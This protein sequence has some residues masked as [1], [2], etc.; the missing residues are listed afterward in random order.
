MLAIDLPSPPWIVGHRG[1]AGEACE[2]TLT[3]FKKG[4]EAGADMLE[5]DVQLPADGVPVCFHDWDLE[6]LSGRSEIVEDEDS[7]LLTEITLSGEGDRIP[8]LEQALAAIPSEAPLN[9][10]LKRRQAEPKALAKS[11]LD[12]L[13][14]RRQ[15]LVSSFDWRLLEVI[16]AL[17]PELPLAPIAR[18]RPG[19]LIDAGRKL[20][21][22]SLHCHRRLATAYFVERAAAAGFERVLAYTLN[23]PVE[24][25]NLVNEGISGFFTDQP[26]LM[27]EHFRES[28]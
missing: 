3:A 1:A 25:R 7:R 26:S 23:E 12:L 21:A 11:V 10:E 13:G 4:L 22:F 5:L 28:E 20:S 19:A 24:A 2:N 17:S 8:T 6:R 18:Y 14:G 15:T 16:R 9:V 27:V